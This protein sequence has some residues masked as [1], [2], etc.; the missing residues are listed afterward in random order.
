MFSVGDTV[1][2]D[3]DVLLAKVGENYDETT[4]TC[5]MS[6][7]GGYVFRFGLEAVQKAFAQPRHIIAELRPDQ[8]IARLT[9][10]S[11]EYEGWYGYDAI[12]PY[13]GST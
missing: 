5:K 2:L 4:D 9:T 11:G 7:S 12:V 13:T 10:P 6:G 8:R 3:K 1:V